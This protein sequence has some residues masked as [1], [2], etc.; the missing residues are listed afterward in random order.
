MEP[1]QIRILDGRSRRDVIST[2]SLPIVGS[3]TYY[4]SVIDSPS[5]AENNNPRIILHSS[6]EQDVTHKCSKAALS[7][8]PKAL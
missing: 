5:H 7:L 1:T 6:A 4:L 2:V 3:H 8:P